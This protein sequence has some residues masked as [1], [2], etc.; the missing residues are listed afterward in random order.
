MGT[1]SILILR[2]LFTQIDVFAQTLCRAP[3]WLGGAV[4]KR[5]KTITRTLNE[6]LYYSWRWKIWIFGLPR[7]ER[8]PQIDHQSSI[9]MSLVDGKNIGEAS[10]HRQ[11]LGQV[12]PEANLI[13]L[14]LTR[15]SSDGNLERA[16]RNTES[17]LCSFAITNSCNIANYSIIGLCVRIATIQSQCRRSKTS[18]CINIPAD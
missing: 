3:A 15:A 9:P 12:Q 11:C 5:P 6:A 8:I 16:S 4:G 2:D 13:I 18:A 1:S 17:S 7:A 14:E 10:R